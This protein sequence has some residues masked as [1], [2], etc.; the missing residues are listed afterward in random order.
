[1]IFFTTR[2]FDQL[3]GLR[4]NWRKLYL[5]EVARLLNA[6]ANEVDD[7]PRSGRA[8]PSPSITGA[9]AVDIFL[10]KST[11]GSLRNFDETL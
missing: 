9:N 3:M 8:F 10:Q 7:Q 5:R 6:D 11:V 2:E 1:M 4:A